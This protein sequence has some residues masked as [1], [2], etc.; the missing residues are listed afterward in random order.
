ML[1]EQGEEKDLVSN[2]FSCFM[3]IQKI[4]KS[5]DFATV[6]N[7]G[8]VFKSACF[9]ALYLQDNTKK[10]FAVIASKKV[11]NAVARNKAKRRI[12]AAFLPKFH[13]LGLLGDYV[14]I[15]RE[16][17]VLAD[18]AKIEADFVKFFKSIKHDK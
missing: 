3:Q 16:K 11:G 15:A 14:I 2:N 9:V 10:R 17:I 8:R 5:K 1:V 7:G 13:K 6:F 12:K 4:N 18:F